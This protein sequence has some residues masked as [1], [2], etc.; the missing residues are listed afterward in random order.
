MREEQTTSSCSD[1]E[2]S[3]VPDQTPIKNLDAITTSPTHLPFG[4]G[5]HACPGRFFAMTEIKI[6]IA[7]IILNYDVQIQEMRP[8]NTCV[9]QTIIPPLK[10]GLM[11]R[12]RGER[13][14]S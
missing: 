10:G 6:L 8:R 2:K 9:G 5:K 4:H 3:E 14:K 11:V 7:Y 12:R 1:P 13:Q